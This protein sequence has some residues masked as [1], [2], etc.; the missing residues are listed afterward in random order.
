MNNIKHNDYINVVIQALAQIPQF[1]EVFLCES[2]YMKKG[3]NQ[4]MKQTPER[5]ML[6]RWGMYL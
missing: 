3:K 1:K 5:I 2:N 4:A 6:Q